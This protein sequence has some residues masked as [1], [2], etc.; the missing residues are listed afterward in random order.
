M[1]KDLSWIIPYRN[2]S[3][4]CLGIYISYH[5]DPIHTHPAPQVSSPKL[6]PK[7]NGQLTHS[8]AYDTAYVALKG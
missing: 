8:L 6:S 5:C 4:L 3:I 1:P 7:V 2:H